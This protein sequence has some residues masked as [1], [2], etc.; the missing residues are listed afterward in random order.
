MTTTF[1]D[2]K[3]KVWQFLAII[4]LLALIVMYLLYSCE[5]N[6]TH[7]NPKE[8]P[9]IKPV[10]NIKKETSSDSAFE[11]KKVDSVL[12]ILDKIDNQLTSTTNELFNQQDKTLFLQQQN[13][14]LIS[15]LQAGELADLLTSNSSATKENDRI[16]DSSLNSIL[17]LIKDKLAAK[18]IIISEKDEL[19]KKLKANL[20][21][22]LQNQT[23]LTKISKQDSV[24]NKVRNKLAIGPVA[25][26]YPVAGIGAGITF[27]HK[28]GIVVNTDVQRMNKD[29]YVQAGVKWV[30]S[31]RKKK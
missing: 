20:D 10:E 31:I 1:F 25:T 26:F 29:W 8:K 18:N 3:L 22:C 16:K 2:R 15:L 24:D 9:F 19:Y 17:A 11:K 14:S 23:S 12:H 30:I 6:K 4:L 5:K 7:S 27:I 21:T 13:D 28:K